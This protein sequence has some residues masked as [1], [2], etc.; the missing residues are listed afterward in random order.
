M[1]RIKKRIE[2]VDYAKSFAIFGVVLLHVECT[3]LTTLIIS[4]F[5]LPLFF[6]ISGYLFSYERN[7]DY[8]DFLIKRA[9]QILWPYLWM[10]VIAY[11]LWVYVLRYFG[12][13][14]QDSIEWYM[15]IY[16]TVLWIPQYLVHDLPLWCLPSF[17]VVELVYYPLGK[18]RNSN[19][20]IAVAA[21]TASYLTYLFI[22]ELIREFPLAAGTALAGLF[23]F[24]FG[25]G[26][27]LQD[28]MFTICTSLYFLPV[29]LLLFILC[30][31]C[32]NRVDFSI[33]YY[34]NF[35]LFVISSISGTMIVFIVS[36]LLAA[37]VYPRIVKFISTVTIII[38][39]IHIL[40]FSFIKG[41]AFFAFGIQPSQ[42]TAGFVPGLCFA[43]AAF[44]VSMLIAYVIRR[45]MPWLLGK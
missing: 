16:G 29:W 25:Q 24:C 5:I 17:F 7:P 35:F 4:A 9:K 19:V 13:N 15:P 10:S 38:C 39:G 23:F 41:I 45:W 37:I 1:S 21:I 43:V 3:Q 22:P 44:A 11:L 12:D 6:T 34:D 42:L 27:R 8:K 36:K 32:D 26:L 40:V 31:I 2:W 28:K 18:I 33:C 14:A 30:I 20:Y